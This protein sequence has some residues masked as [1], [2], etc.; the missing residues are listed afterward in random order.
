MRGITSKLIFLVGVLSQ[1]VYG[2]QATESWLGNRE[3]SLLLAGGAYGSALAKEAEK[4]SNRDV[5]KPSSAGNSSA[6]TLNKNHDKQQKAAKRRFTGLELPQKPS[7][8]EVKELRP[9]TIAELADLVQ[10]RNPQLKASAK[11]VDQAKSLLLSSIASWYPTINLSANGLPQYLDSE[12]FRNPDFSGSNRTRTS[13]WKTAVSITVQWNLIDPKRVPEIAAARDTYEKAKKSYLI[14][15]RDLKLDA[16]SKYFLLQRADEGVRIGK[17]S[18]R[19]SLVSLRDAKARYEAGVATRLDVLE[20][21]TQLARDKQLLTNRLGDQQRTRRV[22]AV[23]LN[24]DQ[25]TTPIAASPAQVIGLWKASLQES[26]IA[27]YAFREELEAAELDISIRN[28]NANS[29]LATQQPTI[30]IVNTLSSSRYQGQANIPT[31]SKID[32][33]DY[34]WTVSNSIG[35]NANWNIFDGGKAKAIYRYNKQRAEEAESLFASQQDLIRNEVE[36]SFFNLQTAN[37]NIATTAREVIASR[38]SLRLA[39]LRFKAGVTTQREVVNNQRDLTQSEVRYSDAITTYN[40]SLAQLKRRTGID[41]SQACKPQA[42][43][44]KKT[45]SE[46]MIEVPIE[47]FPLVPACQAS[48]ISNKK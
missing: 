24:L 14:T 38:E 12:T 7:Q 10:K 20:A 3:N 13:Q 31:S 18:M 30:S 6:P 4:H 8:V 42:I 9:I 47:P 32:R 21:E 25:K 37:Q 36:E 19:A 22:L 5:S 45:Q 28:S 41:H 40:T 46:E 16:L 48:T 35:L 1:S 17:Q 11:Q 33:A 39:R 26:I 29:A 34:G 43:P 2:V 44:K 15:L 27:A 23:I